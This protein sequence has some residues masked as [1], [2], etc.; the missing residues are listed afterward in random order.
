M[1]EGSTLGFN[2]VDANGNPTNPVLNTLV[3]F[4]WEYVYQLPHPEP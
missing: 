2:N 4:G 1:P 3:N